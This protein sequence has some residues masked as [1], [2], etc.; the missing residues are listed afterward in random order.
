[1]NGGANKVRALRGVAAAVMTLS[2]FLPALSRGEEAS[3][4]HFDIGA[5]NLSIALNQFA[6]QSR[7]QI[8][9]APDLVAQKLSPPLRG[10]MQPLAALKLLLKDSGLTFTTTPNGTIL[11]GDPRVPQTASIKV[12][13]SDAS[14]A[15]AASSP[16]EELDTLTVVGARD[17][18]K[19]LRRQLRNFISAITAAPQGEYLARW[20]REV[21]LCARVTGLPLADG[22]FLLDRM[23]QIAA[24]IGVPIAPEYCRPN[25][26]IIVTSQ[27]DELLET[28]SRRDPWIFDS[29]IDEGGKVIRDFLHASTPVR[30]WY[31]V[32]FKGFGPF[33]NIPG[34]PVAQSF[35]APGSGAR[36]HRDLWSVIVVIDA[37]PARGVSFDQLA[38]Y[39]AMVGLARIRSNAKLNDAPTILRL[40]SDP[41]TAPLGLSP[42]DQAY[43]KGLYSTDGFEL[44]QQL[45]I[46]RSMAHQVTP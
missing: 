43:L 11:I 2:L 33:E 29:Q 46:A 40:F 32:A 7:Q 16:D 19:E 45:A 17:R 20:T 37:R 10:D 6:Q 18:E 13:A 3:A 39:T 15:I 24:S 31:N 8:L 42:W 28:W 4:R 36:V 22:E 41:K 5:Q 34:A 35:G 38:A 9:F 30:S 1:M 23:S 25:L 44:P 21:P 14:R 12:P 27:P 26:Q